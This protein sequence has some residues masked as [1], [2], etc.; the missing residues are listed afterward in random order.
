M[1]KLCRFFRNKTHSIRYQ[2]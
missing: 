2:I 1:M